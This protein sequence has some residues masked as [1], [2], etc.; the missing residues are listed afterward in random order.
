MHLNIK[1]V[2]AHCRQFR[3]QLAL[4]SVKFKT[5]ARC[6]AVINDY[7]TCYNIP[8]YTL[9]QH[10]RP[11]RKRGRVALYI[12]NNLQYNVRSN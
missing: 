8:G 5:I 2:P 4:L 3:A 9:K 1:S 7:H 12:A 11:T 10:F 6:E